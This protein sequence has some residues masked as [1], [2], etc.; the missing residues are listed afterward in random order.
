M[1]Q[2]SSRESAMPAPLACLA[3][4]PPR[5]NVSPMCDASHRMQRLRPFVLSSL[6]VA[7]SRLHL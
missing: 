1:W 2:A 7:L 4:A 5:C 6:N 3:A